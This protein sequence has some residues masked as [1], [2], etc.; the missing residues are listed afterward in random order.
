MF[1]NQEYRFNVSFTRDAY[2]EKPDKCAFKDIYFERHTDIT[3]DD[4]VGAVEMGYGYT[5]I[6]N[7]RNFHISYKTKDNF[8]Y[9]KFLAFDIDDTDCSF[10]KAI[11]T[12]VYPP[13][14]AYRTYSDGYE[15]KCSY[16]F[17]YVFNDYINNQNFYEIYNA[18]SS[19]NRFGKD[20]DRREYNQFYFG[21]D[22]QDAYVSY[23][24]YDLAD[25][26]VEKVSYN[27]S[28][29]LILSED[30]SYYTFPEEYYE[31]KRL[32]YYDKNTKRHR[33]RKYTDAGKLSRRKQLYLDGQLIKKIN[34]IDNVEI[35]YRILQNELKLYYDNSIDTITDEELKDIAKRIMRYPFKCK[36]TD[37]HPSFRI[38][39]PYWK[40]IMNV[41][42]NTY[43]PIVAINHIRKKIKIDMFKQLYNSNL[44]YEENMKIMKDNN[45]DISRRTYYNFKKEIN[46]ANQNI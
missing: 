3:I 31:V 22:K 37:K 18:V 25:F 14:I 5:Y 21:T 45:I 13:T 41:N 19:I 28:T 16:R 17:I 32:W 38:N 36:T 2:P 30:E 35:M 1:E 15:D 39:V 27:T 34:D 23:T 10:E 33:I 9:T 46:S 4:F 40:S 29:P 26:N 12:C 6:Y 20:L 44:T 42:N 24:I 43:K 11:D 8:K 7:Q